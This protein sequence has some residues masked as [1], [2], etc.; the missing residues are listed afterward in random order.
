[1]F[2]TSYSK[3]EKKGKVSNGLHR[4][5]RIPL[6]LSSHI[7]HYPMGKARFWPKGK[8]DKASIGKTL[9]MSLGML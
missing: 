6:S 9:I 1:M 2:Y 5:K 3:K 8:D 4:L 7:S